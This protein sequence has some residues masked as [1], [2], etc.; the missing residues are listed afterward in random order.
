MVLRLPSQL[1]TECLGLAPFPRSK[2]QSLLMVGISW[3]FTLLFVVPPYMDVFGMGRMFSLIDP[4]IILQF[5][6]IMKHSREIRSGA[7]WNIMY[8]RLLA[9]KLQKLQLFRIIP[10]HLRLHPSH[11]DNV[12]V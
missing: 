7:W 8:H 11:H 12:N 3:V 5:K 10:R 2:L 1:N 9:W 4:I 6:E